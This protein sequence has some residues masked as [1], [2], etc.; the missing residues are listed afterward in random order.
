LQSSWQERAIVNS[1]EKFVAK[2]KALLRGAAERSI[3]NLWNRISA[4][5]GAFT[6]KECANYF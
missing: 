6:S 5:L 4:L 3:D 2:L 1:I